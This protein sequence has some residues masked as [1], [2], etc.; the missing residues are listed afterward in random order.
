MTARKSEIIG[1]RPVRIW[2]GPIKVS[3]DH[4]VNASYISFAPDGTPIKRTRVMLVHFDYD[5]N[6]VIVGIELF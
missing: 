5:E 2:S 6:D 3:V 4:E 1:E